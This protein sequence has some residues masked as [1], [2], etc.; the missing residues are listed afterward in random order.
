MF[1]FSTAFRLLTAVRVAWYIIRVAACG[2]TRSHGHAA[3]NRQWHCSYGRVLSSLAA[4]KVGGTIWKIDFNRFC[5]KLVYRCILVKL[6][7][8]YF[9]G[10]IRCSSVELLTKNRHFDPFSLQEE[11][12]RRVNENHSSHNS[13]C[14][15]HFSMGIWSHHWETKSRFN[16]RILAHFHPTFMC[17]AKIAKHYS[18]ERKMPEVVAVPS[19]LV[20]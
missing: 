20:I 13:A 9:D 10:C 6:S 16:L 11:M 15:Q 4:L 3:L 5:S 8:R 18:S 7:C 19:H 2:S 1:T 17:S 12:P 14:E